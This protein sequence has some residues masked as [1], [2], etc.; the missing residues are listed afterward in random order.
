MENK[1]LVWADSLK[2]WLITLVVLG[3]A[4][5]YTIGDACYE[6]HIWNLIY[7]FHMPAFMAVSGF[8]AFRTSY[9]YGSGKE[10]FSIIKRRFLQ[11]VIPYYPLLSMAFMFPACK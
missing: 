11:L 5:H 2:G 6:N 8:L 7:S 10:C 4:I 3:H 9:K 1:R